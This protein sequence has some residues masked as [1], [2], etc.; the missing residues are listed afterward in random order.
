MVYFQYSRAARSVITFLRFHV[1]LITESRELRDAVS[2]ADR[3]NFLKARYPKTRTASMFGIPELSGKAPTGGNVGS[4][5]AHVGEVLQ[6]DGMVSKDSN[7]DSGY[8]R[9]E[10]NANEGNYYAD[11]DNFHVPE[12]EEIVQGLF[13]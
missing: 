3:W 2:F 7:L 10:A 1:P 13:S 5:T 4:T 8:S 9:E 6:V 11:N 12:D